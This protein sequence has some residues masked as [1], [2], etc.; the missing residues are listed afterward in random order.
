MYEKILKKYPPD[1]ENLIYILHEIQDSNPQ[2][3]VP[4]EAI[5]VVSEYLK[6]SAA[7]IHGVLTF[8]SMFSTAPRGRNVIRLCESPPCFLK[9]S[10]KIL[11]KLR[12]LLQVKI[13]ETTKDGI[14]TLELCACL[15]VC[16]NAP[17]M[18]INEDIYADLTEEK[19]EKI[20]A[21]IKGR[22]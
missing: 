10:E 1:Q 16:G 3:F 21:E 11:R 18:M 9:G 20:I 5:T 15:G 6:I 13:G 19:V 12:D 7:H 8:Y 17:V 4:E 2:N 22:A 14:F